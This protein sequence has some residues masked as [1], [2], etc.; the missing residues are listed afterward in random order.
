MPVVLLTQN[1]VQ[2]FCIA[3]QYV[4]IPTLGIGLQTSHLQSTTW[5]AHGRDSYVEWCMYDQLHTSRN[6]DWNGQND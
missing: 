6:S 5:A 1:N 4:F 3:P 2:P